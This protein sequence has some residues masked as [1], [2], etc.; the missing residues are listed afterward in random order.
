MLVQKRPNKGR[1]LSC[2]ISKGDDASCLADIKG[3]V[4]ES[5]TMQDLRQSGGGSWVILSPLE[6]SIKRK[7]EGCGVALKEWDISINYGIKTGCNEAF[8][9]DETT[10]QG[11]LAACK[12]QD[13]RKRT[14]EL[15]HPILRG[16]DIKRYRAQW[17]GCICCMCRG[18]SR[19]IWTQ[20][21]KAHLKWRRRHSRSSIQWCMRT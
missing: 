5:G 16:R 13:E 15:T 6:Q 20:Q 19:C 11:I 3:R 18:T 4:E 2:T 10:R 14:E 1:T 9:V 17:A 8:I 12:T 7:I 21:Y